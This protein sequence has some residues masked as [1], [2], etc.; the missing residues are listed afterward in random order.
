MLRHPAVGRL[1]LA[2]G[3][4][5]AQPD[6]ARV[7]GRGPGPD[8]APAPVLSPHDH[9]HDPA[10]AVH[11]AQDLPALPVEAEEPGRSV[12]AGPLEEGEEPVHESGAGGRPA[13]HRVTDPDHGADRTTRQRDLRH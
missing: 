3:A 12:P 11:E 2:H 8:A 4:Q 5:I 10:P 7:A 13:P 9:V 1:H 6:H